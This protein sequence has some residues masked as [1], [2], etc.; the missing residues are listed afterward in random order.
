[1]KPKTY[2]REFA[3]VMWFHFVWLTFN[4]SPEMV[5]VLVWPYIGFILGAFGL[6]SIV[7]QT[8]LFKKVE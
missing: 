2:K 1:M 3:V 7:T 4:S 8:D 5:A 6:Q